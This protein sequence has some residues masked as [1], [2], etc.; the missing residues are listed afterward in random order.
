MSLESVNFQA[1]VLSWPSRLR[2][3]RWRRHHTRWEAHAPYGIPWIS[4]SLVHLGGGILSTRL[5]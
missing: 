1:T 3:P 2:H 5:T 4:S